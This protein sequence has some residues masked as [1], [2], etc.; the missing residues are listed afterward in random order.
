M[1]FYAIKHKDTESLIKE[2]EYFALL[3]FDNL[4][5]CDQ[6]LT[7]KNLNKDEYE[8]VKVWLGDKEIRY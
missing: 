6:Y 1:M 5:C 2:G 3:I 4:K 7:I 8:S